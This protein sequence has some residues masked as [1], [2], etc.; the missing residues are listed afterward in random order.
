MMWNN[1]N[2]QNYPFVNNYP[3][4]ANY[5]YNGNMTTT[6]FPQQQQVNNY[7][8]AAKTQGRPQ[9]NIIWVSGK[10]NARSMQLQPNSRVILLDSDRNK[11]YI[12]ITDQLGLG[13]L[14]VF[15]FVEELDSAEDNNSN[16]TEQ[17][18]NQQ[19]QPIQQQVRFAN[20]EY[21][22]KTELQQIIAALKGEMKDGKFISRTQSNQQR[23]SQSQSQS[24]KK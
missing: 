7:P 6:A 13:K 24:N 11:F 18:Q 3:Y 14:R 16:T 2:Q 23:Q 12:K 19:V 15:N 9:N 10:E 20:Q 1:Y 21:V 8:Y 17:I 5:N 22:T 4:N